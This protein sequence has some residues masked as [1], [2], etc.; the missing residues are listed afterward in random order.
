MAPFKVRYSFLLVLFIIFEIVVRNRIECDETTPDLNFVSNSSVQNS[1][2]VPFCGDECDFGE[3]E[4]TK[5]KIQV[6]A[7]DEAL[8]TRL[9]KRYEEI[10]VLN[11]LQR[12]KNDKITDA[13]RGVQDQFI[14][15][16]GSMIPQSCWY[17]GI[18][19]DCGL[20]ISCVLAG[21]KPLDLCSGGM[22]WSC[23]V[24]PE[25]ITVKDPNINAL[26]NAK[27]TNQTKFQYNAEVEELLKKFE[28]KIK[29]NSEC[30]ANLFHSKR[31][32]PNVEEFIKNVEVSRPEF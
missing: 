2:Q 3:G 25:K 1:S 20:S 12:I 18:K 5:K 10:R 23:C 31:R 7:R 19:F 11:S 21:G 26:Q 32:Q 30:L 17:K 15:M 27:N 8:Q 24:S 13:S 22:I 9:E 4:R 14:E 6:Q 16:L 29:I 28:P